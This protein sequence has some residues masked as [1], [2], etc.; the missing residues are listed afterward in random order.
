MGLA[1]SLVAFLGSEN[2]GTLPRDSAT[3]RKDCWYPVASS[4]SPKLTDR[5][6]AGGNVASPHPSVGW[7]RFHFGDRKSANI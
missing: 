7:K 4:V 6:A 5:V 1:V 2:N 3:K